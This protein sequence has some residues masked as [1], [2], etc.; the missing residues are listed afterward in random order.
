MLNKF[1]TRQTTIGSDK[2]E[3]DARSFASPERVCCLKAEELMFDIVPTTIFAPSL[4]SY[5]WR[6]EIFGA[7]A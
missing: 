7:I 2:T 5:F 1:K 3:T 6:N 4:P